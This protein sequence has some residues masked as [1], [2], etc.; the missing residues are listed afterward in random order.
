LYFSH[1]FNYDFPHNIEEYVHR[2]G[3]TGRAG[4][5]GESISLVTKQDWALAK[6]LISILEEADQVIFYFNYVWKYKI[7]PNIL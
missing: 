5:T 4:R 3:R 2:V 1:I 6:E 7:I